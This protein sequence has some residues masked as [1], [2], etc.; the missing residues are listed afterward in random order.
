MRVAPGTTGRHASNQRSP[1]TAP[2]DLALDMTGVSKRFG[3]TLVLDDVTFRVRGG[4]VHG[5]VGHNGAGK[6]TLMK[7]ALG[8]VAPTSG[9]V[10][11]GGTRLTYSRPA[12]ARSAGVGM[13]LQELSLIPTLSVVDNI[14]LNAEHRSA[15][16]TIAARRERREA[17]DLLLD[18]GITGISTSRPVGELGVA[19]LQMVE[20]VKAIR[21]SRKLLILD[22]PT[23]PLARAEVTRLFDL[24]RRAAGLGLGVVFIT[25]HLRE[26]F[27]ICDEVTVLRDGRIVLSAATPETTLNDVVSAL[28]GRELAAV[29]AEQPAPRAE[30]VPPLLEVRDLDV[31]GK[32]A[33]ISFD[34]YPGQIIGVA[35]L[36]GSGRTV[37]LKSIFGDIRPERA[38]MTLRGR[39]YRPRGPSD[40]I[41]K[42]V[43]LVPE[44]RAVR[45]LVQMHT[46]EQNIVLSILRRLK[47]VVLFRSRVARRTAQRMIATLG[48]RTTGVHQLVQELSGGNQQKVVFSKAL[49]SE[50]DLYLLDE[51]TFGIDV[52]TAAD[53]VRLIREEVEGGKAALWVTSDLTELLRVSDEILVLADGTV[54]AVV[55]RGDAGFAEDALLHAI[56]RQPVT[57]ASGGELTAVGG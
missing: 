23:G 48:I 56:Q 19:E 26:V 24:I 10:S 51:P 20:I 33:G 40:A 16:G 12:E 11:I 46:V 4:S 57:A 50:A 49:L 55:R 22:E 39:R 1:M 28:V 52:H 29:E 54:K 9:T 5:L 17:R 2:E 43:F 30:G 15:L 34:L 45:G 35:G 44:D 53:I 7:I 14:F 27:E 47:N 37:L 42:G 32:L 18:L 3:R 38:R 8:S 21:M 6:S 13:V 31:R 41:A 36:A 25:H